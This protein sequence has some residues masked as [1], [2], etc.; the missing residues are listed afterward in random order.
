M[1]TRAE[2]S[3]CSFSA[4]T[5]FLLSI[6][7]GSSKCSLSQNILNHSSSISPYSISPYQVLNDTPHHYQ[8]IFKTAPS[9]LFGL[10]QTTSANGSFPFT[11]LMM[12][13]K[14]ILLLASTGLVSSSRQQMA[15]GALNESEKTHLLSMS[16]V[17]AFPP[18]ASS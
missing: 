18:E 12:I 3:I 5:S 13:Q 14:S 4:Q 1:R 9:P 6:P 8:G 11:N 10:P 15:C 7:F 16:A 17:T 2:F